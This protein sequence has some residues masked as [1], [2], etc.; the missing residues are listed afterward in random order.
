[1]TARFWAMAVLG[2]IAALVVFLLRARDLRHYRL[3]RGLEDAVRQRTQELEREKTR[4]KCRNRILEMLVT[5]QSL[6]AVLDVIAQLVTAEAP[7]MVCAIV[8][9]QSDHAMVASAPGAWPEL[10]TALQAVHAVPFEV[11]RGA[12]ETHAPLLDPAWSV[13][14]KQLIGPAPEAIRTIRTIRTML[15]GDQDRALGALLVLDPSS[16]PSRLGDEILE[17]GARL[18]WIAIEHS[19]FCE[20]LNFQAH[21]DNLTGLPNRVLFDRRLDQALSEA[22]ST[23]RKAALL[24]L[25]MDCF[26]QINDTMSHRVGDLFLVE[27]AARMRRSLRPG[28][29]VARIGGD[30]FNVLLASVDDA[31]EAEKIGGRIREALRQPVLIEGRSLMATASIGI[32]IFPDD[33]GEA[34]DLRREADAAMYCAKGMGRDRVQLYG[35][36][37]ITLDRV[38]MDHE[39][40][41]ALEDRYFAVHYQPKVDSAGGFAGMEALLRLDHPIHGQIAPSDFIPMAEQSGL[42]VPLGA[43]V[44]DEVCRQINEW[45]TLGLG[46]VPVAVNVSPVQICRP[47]FASMVEECLLRHDT[48]S[49]SIEL[50][51][52]E[53]VL[54]GSGEETQKQMRYL[55]T[56]G[57]R[58]SIDDFGTGYSSLSYLH[59]LQVDAIKLD[60]SF[61]KFID[62]DDAARRLVQA[63]IGVAAALGLGVI[64][65]GV[66]TEEQRTVLVAAGC[67]IMQGFL[68]SR[69]KPA[70][71]LEEYLRCVGSI[72]KQSDPDDLRRIAAACAG[73]ASSAQALQTV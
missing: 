68:F 43:W 1:M 33:G 3:F 72:D 55:R 45:R 71:D 53:T 11:W 44:L 51:L 66:E 39:L 28:D 32:A 52:T 65:E 62:T 60:R 41:K 27:V 38:R 19:R 9:R 2:V 46:L 22:R 4:D 61:V 40:K 56:R 31:A 25:D 42:I 26:K 59:R 24:F 17:L 63:M 64:A 18:A 12:T 8:L 35:T 14:V 47:D 21:H 37:N 70:A 69:P 13:F 54:I 57:I 36:R 10:L 15:I 58:F 30:E 23:N 73:S 48:P 6:Q 67:P 50:E 49:S 16:L 7:E 34:E 29:V 5:N 20:D